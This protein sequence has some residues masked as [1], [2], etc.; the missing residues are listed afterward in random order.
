M[1][2]ILI[3]LGGASGNILNNI[4]KESPND[5]NFLYINTDK[6][7][8]EDSKIENKLHVNVKEGEEIDNSFEDITDSILN[9]VN[10]NDKIF[11]IAGLG[12]VTGSALLSHLGKLLKD[13][14]CPS[15]GIVTKPFNYEGKARM[16]IADKS[17]E[18]AKPFYDKIEIFDNQSMFQY[19][20]KE[21]TFIEAFKEMDTRIKGY[22]ESQIA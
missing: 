15:I 12:G 11:V 17:L 20:E 9:H 2:V 16:E 1:K 3:G 8:I 7:S 21:T 10:E 5:F 14:N 18:E 4:A 19:A 13:N 6:K 22:I